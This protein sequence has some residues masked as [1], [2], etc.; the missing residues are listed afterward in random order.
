[1]YLESAKIEESKRI[2]IVHSKK[3]LDWLVDFT[4]YQQNNAWDDEAILYSPLTSNYDKKYAS[5]LSTFQNELK[6]MAQEQFVLSLDTHKY[7]YF[8]YHFKLRGNYYET[9]LLDGNG[10][11]STIK[12]INTPTDTFIYVD[13]KI[14]PEKKKERELVEFIL[15]NKDLDITSSQYSVHIAHSC[16][17]AALGEYN[18]EEFKIWNKDGTNQKIIILKTSEEELEKLKDDFYPSFDSGHNNIKENTLISISLGILSRQQAKQY[19]QNCEL[20]K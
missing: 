16:T 14:P 6:K 11:V 12:K 5:L 3:Y 8:K 20:W 13:E 10:A 7:E 4:E 15:I 9:V 19:T 17:K 18:K 1:M 2:K